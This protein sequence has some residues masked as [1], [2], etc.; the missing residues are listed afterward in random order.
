M[1]LAGLHLS[2]E[3]GQVCLDVSHPETKVVTR[4][5]MSGEAAGE[6]GW[7]LLDAADGVRPG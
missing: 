6:L 2:V 5:R 7:A 4:L 1:G 3:A